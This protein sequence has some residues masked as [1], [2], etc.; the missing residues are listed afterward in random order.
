M[1]ICLHHNDDDGRCAAAIVYNELFSIFVREQCKFIEYYHSEQIDL[2][3]I[4]SIY[5]G[6]ML[7]IVDLSL[8]DN[9]YKVIEKGVSEGM[10]V[11]HI[12]H[13]K[14]TLDFINSMTTE[15]HAILDKIIKFYDTTISATMLTWV[16][17]F[18]TEEQQ[19][20]PENVEYDFSE[21]WSHLMI[22]GKGE[23]KIPR[24]VYLID[25]YDTWRHSS[26]DSM[27]FN[28]GFVS[29]P[30]KHPTA[31]IWQSLM[32]NRGDVLT[33]KYVEKG[34]AIQEFKEMDNEHIR[35][36]GYV[37]VF[38]IDGK[39]CEIFCINTVGG[40]TTFGDVLKNY[41]AGMLFSY[42]GRN[43]MWKVMVRSHESSTFDCSAFAA[44]RGGGG[45][46]HAAGFACEDIDWV[47][48]D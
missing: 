19:A 42:D 37:K 46:F 34:K 6:D 27:R 8:D 43:H 14:S 15:Q 7:V 28:Y 45:H 44:Q 36:R 26:P 41:D 35:K 22:K 33:L 23:G 9:I 40:T 39:Q 1:P 20:H 17:S 12:D 48:G 4:K 47:L 31:D 29:E 5:P 10:K 38:N 11:I 18:M 32:Y 30:N 21:G 25:D 16:Y 24:V 13:H 3:E 2:N